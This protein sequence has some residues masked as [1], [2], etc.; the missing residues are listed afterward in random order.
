VLM[1]AA[2]TFTFFSFSQT[3][4]H[5]YGFPAV[6]ALAILVA[7]WID[8]VLDEG[9]GKH[10]MAWVAGGIVFAM[11]AQNLTTEP[12]HLVDLFVYNY[13]RPY[14][15]R[16]VDPQ[17]AFILLFTVGPVVALFGAPAIRNW[18]VQLWN[19]KPKLPAESSRR[20]I[21]VTLVVLPVVAIETGLL[22]LA[23]EGGKAS[24][25]GGWNLNFGGSWNIP[26]W[27]T[28]QVA[29]VAAGISLVVTLLVLFIF[30]GGLGRLW[31]SAFARQSEDESDRLFVVGALSLLAFAFAVYISAYHWRKI[32]PHWTQRDLFWTYLQESKPSEP[33][34][35]YQMNWRGETFYSRNTVRQLKEPNELRD[36]VALPGKEWVLVEHLRL[37][38][39][40]RALGPQ[41][42]VKVVEKNFTDKFALLSVE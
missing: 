32:T 6:P 34:A 39:L 5:H 26:S 30:H 12:K 11:V 2:T 9:V 13:D 33:I 25:F 41:Y 16:E 27:S 7:I 8:R 28:G 4:F 38:D 36:Y 40:K 23:F 37:A 15:A 1:W 19:R 17:R 3:K 10:A 31:N 24:N 18:F 21:L 35:A 42:K 14:P 20:S 29:A 22:M